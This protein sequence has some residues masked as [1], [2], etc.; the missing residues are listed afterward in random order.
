MSQTSWVIAGTNS[1]LTQPLALILK[2]FLVTKWTLGNPAVTDIRFRNNWWDGYGSYQVH[3]IQSD[4]PIRVLN[5][6]WNYRQ[7]DEYVMI[8][9]F[10]RMNSQDKPIQA[11]AINFEIQ[12][13]ISENKDQLQLVGSTTK[14]SAMEIVQINEEQ[15]S[16]QASIW[17]TILRVYIRY[18]KVAS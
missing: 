3:V 1:D 12:R 16:Q 9:S 17:H 5:L 14:N 6:G 10:V 8:H 7:Y 15:L 4:T 11:D 13:I 2:N 18:W